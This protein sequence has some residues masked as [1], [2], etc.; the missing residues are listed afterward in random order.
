MI[1]ISKRPEKINELDLKIL[2]KLKENA[3][4]PVIDIASELKKSPRIISYRIRQLIKNKIITGF[5]IGLNP[6]KLGIKHYKVFLYL[7]NP[8]SEKIKKIMHYFRNN[9]N[10]V[11][12]VRAFGNW[13]V[14]LDFEVYSDEEFNEIMLEIKDQ[15]SDIIKQIETIVID[16]EHKVDYA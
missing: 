8:N 6:Q 16:K 7:E 14:E 13:D 10:I 9:K 3:R 5:H 4:K 15:F 1:S 2:K 12:Y 11:Y